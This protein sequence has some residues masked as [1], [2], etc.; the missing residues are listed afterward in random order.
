ML[1]YY[2][3]FAVSTLAMASAQLVR[4]PERAR[5]SLGSTQYSTKTHE[6]DAFGRRLKRNAW[7]ANI[8]MAESM[9]MVVSL[10]TKED[11][12]ASTSPP[13][14]P[15]SGDKYCD[16]VHQDICTIGYECVINF[17]G[18]LCNT[19]FANLFPSD[20]PYLCKGDCKL[21]EPSVITVTSDGSKERPY[22]SYEYD[23][24]DNVANDQA[25]A[26]GLCAASGYL[27]GAFV[28]K[29]NGYGRQGSQPP[30]CCTWPPCP[31]LEYLVLHDALEDGSINTLPWD[32]S[33]VWDACSNPYNT[34]AEVTAVCS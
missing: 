28:S 11:A 29:S 1:S 7:K 17:G 22:C 8:D 5:N 6:E 31:G 10:T 4:A 33:P 14:E 19:F 12:A 25:C 18:L 16:V 2:F 27:S 30:C 3:R 23:D 20:L 32:G 15:P 26:T 24:E 34:F 21:R 9:P 13:Y